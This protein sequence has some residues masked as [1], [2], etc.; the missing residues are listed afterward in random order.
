MIT[1]EK[2]KA[3]RKLLEQPVKQ[4]W[5]RYAVYGDK[6]FRIHPGKAPVWQSCEDHSEHR[7]NWKPVEFT[8]PPE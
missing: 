4:T 6:I 7:D 1:L 8:N 3:A 2:M 5:P